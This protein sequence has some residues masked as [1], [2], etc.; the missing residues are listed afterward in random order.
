MLATA[1]NHTS[2]NGQNTTCKRF[3]LAS[4][5]DYKFKWISLRHRVCG[6]AWHAQD[7]QLFPKNRLI[8]KKL[9]DEW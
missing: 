9:L 1:S 7:L 4:F 5:I 8:T 2:F 3:H 6:T